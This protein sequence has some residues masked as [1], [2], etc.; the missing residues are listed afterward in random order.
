MAVLL[1]DVVNRADIR[2]IKGRSSLGLTL[3]PCQRLGVS[4]YL[5]G[6]KLQG[7][8]TV[9]SGVLSLVHHAHPP[10]PPSFSTMR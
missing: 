9:Q 8:E 1:T 6:Q 3:E 10:P 7:H 4:R 2:V 5:I